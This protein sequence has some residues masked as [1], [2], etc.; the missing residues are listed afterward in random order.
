M[1]VSHAKG[2]VNRGIGQLT[3]NPDLIRKGQAEVDAATQRGASSSSS[4]SQASSGAK[5]WMGRSKDKVNS[6]SSSLKK[7]YQN[8]MTKR[9]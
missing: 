3:S 5:D 4:A 6:L 9:R 1:N 2:Q 7:G 8:T